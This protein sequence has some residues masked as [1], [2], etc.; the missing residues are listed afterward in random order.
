[1]GVALLRAAQE[2]AVAGVA[3][4]PLKPG[5][6]NPL[7]PAAHP[8]NGPSDRNCRGECGRLGHGLYDATTD[9]EVVVGWWRSWPAANIGMPTGEN[10]ADVLD[11]DDHG[12]AGNGFAALRKI[13]DAGLATG[14]HRLVRTPRGGLHLYFRPTGNGCHV[15]RR[16]HL[17]CRGDGGYVVVPPSVVNGSAYELL[18]DR[19][20]AAG[21][22][23]WDLIAQLL[24][25][26]RRSRAI[27]EQHGDS[28][29]LVR[30][31]SHVGEGGRNGA[32]FWACCRLVEAGGDLPALQALID[33][34]VSTGLPGHEA[35][36]TA[37]SALRRAGIAA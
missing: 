25:P 34:A 3:V 7:I 11:V 1:M 21:T 18:Q 13:R 33:A 16:H 8:P 31:L 5:G 22:L 32:L 26:P 37:L 14:G 4:F 29:A 36:R 10:S 28:A 17:D 24:D 35:E 20:E 9:P 19:P 23:Q 30:W 12:E 27:V 15:L 6:K 2:L